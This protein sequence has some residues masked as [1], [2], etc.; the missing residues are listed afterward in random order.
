MVSLLTLRFILAL[1]A[2]TIG[3]FLGALA[4]YLGGFFDMLIMRWVDLMLA[5]PDFFVLL[6]FA[7]YTGLNVTSMIFF[8][9]AFSWMGMARLVRGSFLSLRESLMVE[10]ARSIG[11]RGP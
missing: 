11:V 9:G 1:V 2:V 10:S 4:G 3:V 6:I 7:S 8:I 5:V